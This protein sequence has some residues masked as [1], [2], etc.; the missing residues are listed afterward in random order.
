MHSNRYTILFTASLTVI[1]G[2]FI[3]IASGSLKTMQE[4]NIENDSKKN[5]LVSLGYKESADKRWTPDDIQSIFKK[6][7]RSLVVDKMGNIIDNNQINKEPDFNVN[8]Y[9]IYTDQENG[10]TKGYAIPI[11]GKGLW[12][13]LYGYFAIEPDGIT[14]KGITFY[15]HKETPGLGGEVEKPWFQKNFIGKKFINESG[16]LIGIE[17]VKGK[18]D[19]ENLYQVDGISGATVTSKGVEKFLLNDLKKYEPFFNKIR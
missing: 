16:K 1:L 18:S 2:L 7:I 13:T 5:I 14:A 12:S 6:N 3:S 8:Y 15:A 4:L 10:V 19:P 11:S 9:P 17:V